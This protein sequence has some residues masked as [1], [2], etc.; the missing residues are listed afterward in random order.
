M[1]GAYTVTQARRR[2]PKS[3][4][5]GTNKHRIQYGTPHKDGGGSSMILP[6][7]AIQPSLRIATHNNAS[8]KK[9]CTCTSH[10]CPCP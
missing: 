4:I 9:L 6:A 10:P 5:H 8:A 2:L 7:S 1:Q 3:H